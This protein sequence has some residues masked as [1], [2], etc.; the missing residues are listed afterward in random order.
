[1][2][3]ALVD[4]QVIGRRQGDRRS[5]IVHGDGLGGDVAVRVVG[6]LDL[7]RHRAR[8]RTISEGADE[9]AT[10]GGRGRGADLDPSGAAA[11]RHNREGVDTDIGDREVV[12]VL[13]GALVDRQVIARSQ[14]HGRSDIVHGDDDNLVVGVKSAVGIGD[15]GGHVR[16]RRPIS[17]ET[18]EIA[19]TGRRSCRTRGP[20]SR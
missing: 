14:G 10:R 19:S 3:R 12:G 2:R 20:W 7:D 4:R 9:T 16:R 17:E 13:G 11:D 15:R 6:V 5:D 1:M 8:R 18:L